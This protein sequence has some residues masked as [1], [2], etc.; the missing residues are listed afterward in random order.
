VCRDANIARQYLEYWT[1]LSSDPTPAALRAENDRA[2]PLPT[3][4]APRQSLTLFSPRSSDAP[5]SLYTELLD[6]AAESVMFTAAFGVNELFAN[7]LEKP[8][9]TLVRYVLLEK[10]D[11][12]TRALKTVD[13]TRLAVR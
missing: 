3:S 1:R 10:D 9:A 12:R 8:S 4:L 13:G 5:L 6:S 11:K 7:N 2:S